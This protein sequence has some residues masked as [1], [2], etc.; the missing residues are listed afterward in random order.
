[1]TFTFNPTNAIGTVRR[2]IGMTV[3]DE[4]EVSDEEISAWLTDNGD[5]ENAAAIDILRSLA[6]TYAKRVTVTSGNEKIEYSAA[7]KAFASL[8]DTLTNSSGTANTLTTRSVRR[9]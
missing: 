7:S 2:K 9:I 8:A 3:E 6:A 5:D 1:M 4:S